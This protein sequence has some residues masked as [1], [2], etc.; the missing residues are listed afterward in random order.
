MTE[1]VQQWCSGGAEELV[2]VGAEMQRCRGGAEWVQF[3]RGAGAE[4]VQGS[5]EVVQRWTDVVH[6]TEVVQRGCAEVVQVQRY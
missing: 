1:P 6:G 2:Q 5:A 3:S 4:V